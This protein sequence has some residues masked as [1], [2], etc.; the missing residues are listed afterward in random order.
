MPKNIFL[1]LFRFPYF[2]AALLVSALAELK[3]EVRCKSGAIPVAVS[4]MRA[5]GFEKVDQ[6]RTI[7]ETQPTAGTAGGKGSARASQKT[8]LY[9]VSNHAFG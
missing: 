5:W 7:A 1:P 6:P 2:C 9:C 3:W 8:C 4:S